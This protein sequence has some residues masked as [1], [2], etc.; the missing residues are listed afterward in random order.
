MASAGCG[1]GVGGMTRLLRPRSRG[2]GASCWWGWGVRRWVRVAAAGHQG[3]RVRVVRA[4]RAR[5]KL[6]PPLGLARDGLG[7]RWGPMWAGSGF[8]SSRHAQGRVRPRVDGKRQNWEVS[9]PHFGGWEI[10]HVKGSPADP[11]RLYASQS[12]GWFGQLIQRSNDG[13]KTWERSGNKFVY[14]GG[15]GRISGTTARRIPGSSSACGTSSR[16]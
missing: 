16:R 4:G 10:Y 14:D 15:P 5:L 9:G 2:G 6:R 7:A 12:S 8:W 1:G 13:G 3:S 11:N